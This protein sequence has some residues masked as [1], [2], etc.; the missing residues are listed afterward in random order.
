MPTSQT[1]HPSLET[2]QLLQ[3]HLQAL[4]ENPLWQAYQARLRLLQEVAIR[5]LVSTEPEP[6]L[7]RLQGQISAYQRAQSLLNEVVSQFTE[8]L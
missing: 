5:T 2:R 3:E 8:K 4:E 7:R 1:S 6:A